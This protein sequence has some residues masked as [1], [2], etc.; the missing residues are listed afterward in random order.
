MRVRAIA[1]FK[2]IRLKGTAKR[3]ANELVLLEYDELKAKIIKMF[4]HTV[5]R[6]QIYR[7]LHSR[8]FK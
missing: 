4:K 7:Q 1:R 8:T 2:G 5:S 6:Q 3:Y